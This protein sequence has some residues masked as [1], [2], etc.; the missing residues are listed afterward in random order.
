MPFIYDVLK[1]DD[2][3]A[4][5]VQNFARPSR[6]AVRTGTSPL[7]NP[8]W[9]TL[10]LE[11]FRQENPEIEV[12]LHEQNMADLYRMLDEGLLDFVFGVVDTRKPSWS[13]ILLYSEP[14]Y[15]IPRG[16]NHPVGEG[17]VPFDKIAGEVFV[18]VPNVCGLARATRALFRS[19]RRK[20]NEYSGEALSYQVLEQWASLGLG[21]AILPKSK[22]QASERKAYALTDKNGKELALA[23]EAVWPS[24]AGQPEHL[25][26][27]TAFLNN[28]QN[29]L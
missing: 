27:F 11:K 28:Y 4:R 23:F 19:H 10:M 15:F 20:L 29:G 21:A 18:M 17:V 24:S 16:T 1:A 8:A 22:I 9:L 14:L 6:A 25:K 3:L 7:I 2:G 5:A 12:I 13:N 26:K